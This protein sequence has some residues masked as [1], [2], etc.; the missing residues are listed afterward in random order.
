MIEIA[1]TK[2][3]KWALYPSTMNS[4]LEEFLLTTC[5]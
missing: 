3:E 2:V 5:L 1:L 4:V